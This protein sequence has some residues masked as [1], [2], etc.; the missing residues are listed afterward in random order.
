MPYEITTFDAIHLDIDLSKNLAFDTETKG[1]YGKIQLAQFYQ[2]HWPRPLIVKHPDIKELI[3]FLYEIKDVN[4]VM[5]QAS[6]DVAVVQRQSKLPYVPKNFDD[7]LLLS[8]LAFPYFEEFGLEFLLQ[9]S[10]GFDPYKSAGINKEVMQKSNWDEPAPDQLEY[11]AIDVFY[12]LDL[13]EIVKEQ[14]KTISYQLDILSL[15]YAMEFQTNGIPVDTEKLLKIEQSNTQRIKE[16]SLPINCNSFAQVRKYIESDESDD[17]G[18]SKLSILG[19]QKAKDV[20][21]TRKLIKQN[22][23][24]KNYITPDERIYGVFGPYARSGRFT[25]KADNLQQIPRALKAALG[26]KNALIYADFSQLELRCI[27]AITNDKKL[28]DLFLNGD[29]V[30]NYTAQMCF[31]DGYTED[32]RQ[33]AKACNFN[34]LYGGGVRMLQSIIIKQANRFIE[35]EALYKIVNKW[36]RLFP[37]LMRWQE[38]GKQDFNAGRLGTTP[39]GRQYKAKMMTDQ[40][41]IQNQ[42]FGAEVAKLAMHYM[43]PKLIAE[44]AQLINFVHDSYLVEVEDNEEKYQKCARIIGEAMQEAWVEACQTVKVKGIKMPVKI[45]VGHNWKEIESKQFKWSLEL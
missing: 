37:G 36:K 3:K 29:D 11:A 21:E 26:T 9:N 10:L 16:I 45:L 4:I 23:F 27:A 34:L 38:N 40:L 1:L 14:K 5:Q 30:H 8:R 7:T 15:K 22:S 17:L 41:N 18:L 39:F 42:G 24:I 31:G 43:Y 6:Y 35:L 44:G 25:C 13:Y 12:L 2:K 20:R 32:D 28:V 19:N 33:V